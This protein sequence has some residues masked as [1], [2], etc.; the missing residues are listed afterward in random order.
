MAWNCPYA[1]RFKGMLALGCKKQMEIGVDYNLRDN[2]TNV[3]CAFQRYCP[4][5]Q[6]TINSDGAKQCTLL[7]RS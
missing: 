2:Q 4:I 3:L 1:V 5:E 7:S 6:K